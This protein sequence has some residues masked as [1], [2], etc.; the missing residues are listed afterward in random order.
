MGKWQKGIQAIHNPIFKHHHCYHF[1]NVFPQLCLWSDGLSGLVPDPRLPSLPVKL[2]LCFCLAGHLPP[3]LPSV[4]QSEG[5]WDKSVC[6]APSPEAPA[7]RDTSRKVAP[8][9]AGQLGLS[10]HSDC[11]DIPF[12][13]LDTQRHG[14]LMRS[15]ARWAGHSRSVEFL[16]VCFVFYFFIF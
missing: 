7:G 6:L 3:F 9:S 12:L 4:Q 14:R 15:R 10:G 11:W 1:L 2:V 16:F 5:P 13:K 8:S